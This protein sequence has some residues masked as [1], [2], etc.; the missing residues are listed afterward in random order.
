MAV[1]RGFESAMSE[2][3]SFRLNP[4]NPR[5]AQALEILRAKKSEGFSSRQVLTDAL[6]GM[7]VEKGKSASFPIEEFNWN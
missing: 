7:V 3:I 5:E 2:V 6:I 4:E 1:V